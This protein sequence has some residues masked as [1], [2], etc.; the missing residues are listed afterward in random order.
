MNRFDAADATDPIEL[1]GVWFQLATES[2][3]NDPSAMSL[4]TATPDA[5]PSVRMVL[6]KHFDARGFTFYTNVE[7]QKGIEISANPHAALCFHWKSLRRQVRIEGYVEPVSEHDAD[8]Y[9]HS[10]SRRS[11]IGALASQQSRPLSSREELERKAN[12]LAEQYPGEILRP[13]YWSG[14]LVVPNRIEFWQDGPDRLHDRIVF[15][16]S[17]ES[18][19]KTRL[20][21]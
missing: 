2:E 12:A 21:P 18:W 11:Q 16:R 14:Y 20:Y 1:F 5:L 6:M 8:D 9:F 17:G 4:A 10:R 19:T 15:T 13:E 3:P 7:S